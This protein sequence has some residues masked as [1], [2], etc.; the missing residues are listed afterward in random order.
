MISCWTKF[1]GRFESLRG[2]FAWTSLPC[3][4]YVDLFAHR[5][6]SGNVYTAVAA[7]LGAGEISF[8]Y[9]LAA[10]AGVPLLRPDIFR[11]SAIVNLGR[12][13]FIDRRLSLVVLIDR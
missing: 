11:V 4:H 10:P 5:H 3:K 9:G 13:I 6:K 2:V 7:V 1:Y 12:L 8:D